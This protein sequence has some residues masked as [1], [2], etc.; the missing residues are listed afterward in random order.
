MVNGYAMVVYH[1][2]VLL[3]LPVKATSLCPASPCPPTSKLSL[4]AIRDL[5]RLTVC[6]EQAIP[7]AV[8]EAPV[9]YHVGDDVEAAS[10][11][12]SR[13]TGDKP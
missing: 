8:G 12:L 13:T 7:T 6:G 2:D 9:A 3:R 10:G 4:Q 11:S 5:L 1:G